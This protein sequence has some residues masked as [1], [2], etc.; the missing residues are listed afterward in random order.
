MSETSSFKFIEELRQH[1]TETDSKKWST[2]EK[3]VS[4]IWRNYWVGVAKRHGK[5]NAEISK[6]M[7]IPEST[8]RAITKPLPYKL[9]G[10]RVVGKRQ[11]D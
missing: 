1:M 8:V 3:M 5:T 6:G 11:N 2:T 9:P 7:D 4:R 10:G